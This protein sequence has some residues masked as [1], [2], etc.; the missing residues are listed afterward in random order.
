[1]TMLKLPDNRFELYQP[2]CEKGYVSR[3]DPLG[4]VSLGQMLSY[5]RDLNEVV[6]ESFKRPELHIAP[7]TLP[8]N[9]ITM[10]FD[11]G[12]KGTAYFDKDRQHARGDIQIHTSSL[13]FAFPLLPQYRVLALF[14][15]NHDSKEFSHIMFIVDPNAEEL[16]L[17]VDTIY[18]EQRTPFS[19]LED[20]ADD[21][22]GYAE[23][24][25]F[26]EEHHKTI[27]QLLDWDKL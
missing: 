4:P 18:P 2:W 21:D 6:R 8:N 26:F 3:H 5:T 25:W 27:C 11:H 19:E 24:D 9:Q 7:M 22:L 20:H 16:L 17:L 12:T 15:L 13:K 1:M 10:E 14:H 23:T